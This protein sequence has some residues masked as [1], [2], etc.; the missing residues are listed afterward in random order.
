MSITQ[1]TAA[2]QFIAAIAD[3]IRDLGE[4]PSGHLY[5]RLMDRMDLRTYNAVIETLKRAELI[6][7]KQHLITWVG[8]ARAES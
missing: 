3:A 7:V 1:E 4:I 8:P 6:E 2:V 5:A